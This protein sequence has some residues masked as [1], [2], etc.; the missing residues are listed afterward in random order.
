MRGSPR[1]R[2]CLLVVSSCVAL[3]CGAVAA[4]ALRARLPAEE[5]GE[6]AAK[7]GPAAKPGVR[8]GVFESR[9]IAVAFAHSGFNTEVEKLTA[10]Y[11]QAKAAGD[12]KRMAAVKEKASKRQDRL[13]R[14]G[15]GREPVDNLLVHV[16]G[17][18]P[19]VCEEARVDLIASGIVHA[20]PG[21]ERVDVTDLL[22]R[23][24]HP[25]ESTLKMIEDLKKH[26]PLEFEAFP[27]ED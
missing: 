8:V 3:A 15:F 12:E 7:A 14:Q 2:T 24:F 1:S 19:R 26:E 22:V 5:P 4:S 11:D 16:R 21:V 17:R 10:E 13:H 23:E 25:D 18:L 6:A 27:I 9:A 20:M